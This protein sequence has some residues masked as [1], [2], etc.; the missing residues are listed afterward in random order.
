MIKFGFRIRTKNGL[1]VDNL[2][3]QARDQAEAEHKLRQMYHRCEVVECQVIDSGAGESAP[4][5][6]SF[7]SLVTRQA[8]PA[9]K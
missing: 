2:A 5:V 4:D 8:G 9:K 6:D 3:I 7:I 1:Q